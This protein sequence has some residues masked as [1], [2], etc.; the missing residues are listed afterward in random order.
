[1]NPARWPLSTIVLLGGC[2]CGGATESS[3]SQA[4]RPRQASQAGQASLAIPG[5]A[6]PRASTEPGPFA[7]IATGKD[8]TCGLTKEKSL[9]C[10]GDNAFTSPSLS[11]SSIPPPTRTRPSRV[12]GEVDDFDVAAS[13]GCAA[14][15]GGELTC[16]VDRTVDL[17][18]GSTPAPFLLVDPELRNEK[19]A[20]VS[21]FHAGSCVRTEAGRAF[22]V[23]AF[24]TELPKIGA[25]LG[26]LGAGA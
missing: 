25:P 21:S 12:L 11:A 5:E 6:A 23:E 10:W 16:W 26:D 13:H 2:T 1:M 7:R 8:N 15:S 9:W 4:T 22:R 14:R 18:G 24:R 3:D 20:Q 19:V 17:L